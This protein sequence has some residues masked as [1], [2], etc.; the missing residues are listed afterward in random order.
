MSRGAPVG[1][2]GGGGD[3]DVVG[4]HGRPRGGAGA[5]TPRGRKKKKNGAGLLATRAPE[6]RR[7]GVAS[8]LPPRTRAGRGGHRHPPRRRYPRGPARNARAGWARMGL[9]GCGAAVATHGR[10][11]GGAGS[12]T[13]R[14]DIGIGT[15]WLAAR[16]G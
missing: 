2:G 9:K 10:P 14:D 4:P 8:W 16:A 13:S 7:G 5:I 15:R 12:T 1:R 6:G 11:R 3:N